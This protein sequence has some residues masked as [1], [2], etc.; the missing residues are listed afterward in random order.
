MAWD[1]IVEGHSIGVFG[2]SFLKGGIVRRILEGFFVQSWQWTISGEE[3]EHF[4]LSGRTEE[5]GFTWRC[6]HRV[7]WRR[8]CHHGRERWSLLDPRRVNGRPNDKSTAESKCF[9]AILER[10]R[11]ALETGEHRFRWISETWNRMDEDVERVYSMSRS[12]R[13][14]KKPT[15]SQDRWPTASRGRA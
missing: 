11:N 2:E 12:C 4:F 13:W 5:R 3:G 8:C 1:V 9:W 7:R 15:V 14:A 6:R 10:K